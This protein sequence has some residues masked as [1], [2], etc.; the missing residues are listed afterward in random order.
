MASRLAL[1]VVVALGGIITSPAAGMDLERVR[2]LEAAGG[3]A[4]AELRD[5]AMYRALRDFSGHDLRGGDGPLAPI[6]FE[7]LLLHH[8]HRLHRERGLAQPFRSSMPALRWSGDRVLI[9]ML[10]D[11]HNLPAVHTAAQRLGLAGSHARERL[12]SG[13]FPISSLPALARVP[14]LRYARP[15]H[16]IAGS[17]AAVSRGDIALA[18]LAAR[19]DLGVDGTG[20]TVGVLSDSYDCLGGA[21]TDVATGD[22]PADVRVLEEIAVCAGAT[23]EGR[24][25]MQIVR[26]LAP[27]AGQ[28]F[29]SAFNGTAA[30]AA[31][32]DALA[33]VGGADVIV[34]DV[35][36]LSEPWFQDGIVAGAVQAAVAS[37]TAYFSSAGNLGRQSYESEFRPSGV[38]GAIGE[39]HDFDPGP[40][41]DGLQSVTVPAGATIRLY[42][43]WD[44]P[45]FSAT[46]PPGAAT[47]MALVLYSGPVAIAAST[48]A[49]IGGD[50][51]DFLGITNTGSVDGRVALAIERA[52]GPSPSRVKYLYLG[53]LEVDEYPEDSRAGTVFGH[54]NAAGARAVG[55]AFYRSTPAYGTDP[56][57]LESFSSREGVT[58][59]LD[60]DGRR[61]DEPRLKPEIV[62]A[63]GVD[64]TFFGTSDPDATG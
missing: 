17:G 34:D 14:G 42:L 19:N 22:L 18:A 51:F 53:P 3:Q 15:V 35:G 4:A 44:Q 63:D 24:A 13:W 38:A 49:N 27:G 20:V 50:A 37:G 7:L 28:V 6:G 10:A 29:H 32:I 54:A 36:V 25:M 40:A 58:I 61:V 26:D 23:D 5:P 21:S 62:A 46:G 2:T 41:S 60:A 55:A 56:P 11:R 1:F 30:F 16:V 12:V 8:E 64:T 9:D 31:G 43:Q 47:D 59:R 45:F 33:T 48:D 39:R 52:S 57:E